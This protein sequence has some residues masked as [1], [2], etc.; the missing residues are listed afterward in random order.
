M[1]EVAPHET[2]VEQ[3]ATG[4]LMVEGP[5]W[6]ERDG[7]AYLAFS[8]LGADA[9]HRWYGDGRIS[10]TRHPFA[11]DSTRS[12]SPNGITLDSEGRLVVCDMGNR[13]IVR[14]ESDRDHRVLVSRYRGRKLNSPNDLVYR[15]DGSLYFT[16]PP[17]GLVGGDGSPDKEQPV[18]GVYRLRPDGG[19]DLLA[20]DLPRP[21]GIAFSPDERVLYV[22]NSGPEPVVVEAYTVLV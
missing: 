5:V 21:N 14:L 1:Y 12:G 9:L 17:H 8:D 18:N 15:S 16:D 10:T 3:I 6:V 11:R 13:R 19:I 2:E 22:S 4:F 7:E 20:A